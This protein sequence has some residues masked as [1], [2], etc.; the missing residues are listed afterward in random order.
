MKKLTLF[1]LV[2]IVALSMLL[3]GCGGGAATTTTSEPTASVQPSQTSTA[4]STGTSTPTA[5][6]TATTPA[7]PYGTINVGIPDFSYDQF[8][9]NYYT[10][11]WGYEIYDTLITYDKNGNFVGDVAQSWEISPDGNT[12]TFHIRHDIYFQDGTQ[13]TAKDVKF[14]VDRFSSANSTNPWSPYLNRNYASTSTPDDFTFVYVTQHP[15]PTLAAVFVATWILPMDYFNRVGVDEFN[16]KPIGSGPWIMT[17]HVPETSITFTANTKHWL[18]PPAFKTLVINQVPEE[19]TRVAMYKNGSLDIITNIST[20]RLVE[21]KNAGSQVRNVG[22][23]NEYTIVWPGTWIN[24]GPTSDIRVRQAMSYAIN[25]Q[26][27][28]DTYF[29]GTATPGGRWF[30]A[31]G[32]WGWQDSWKADPYDPTLAKQLLAQAGYPDAFTTPTIDFYVTATQEDFAQVLQGYW[33]AIG[34]DVKITVMESVAWSG[35]VFVRNE[36][37][38]APQAGGMWMWGPFPSATNAVYQSA[39]MYTS[40]GVH[41]TSNDPQADVL[42]NKAVSDI[43]PTQALADWDTFL[44][45]AYNMWVNTGT[46]MIQPLTLVSDKIGTITGRTWISWDDAYATVQHSASDTPPAQ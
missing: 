36:D 14:S 11:T 15:E 27:I 44:D 42:Y 3:I 7:G 10:A 45:Y 40:K 4:T 28:C 2:A 38:T 37:P 33:E 19:A 12:W 17:D 21:M 9:P 29:Q 32:S 8:D 18:N 43:D 34:L 13:L 39:N 31:P 22:L 25:R 26:E 23:P 46:V 20:D 6:A 5:T 1:A 41:T 24:K 30:L 16:K 35:I